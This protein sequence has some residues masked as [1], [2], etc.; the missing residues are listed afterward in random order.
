[1][2][3]PEFNTEGTKKSFTGSTARPSAAI[4]HSRF[5]IQEMRCSRAENL[6]KPQTFFELVAQKNRVLFYSVY[7]VPGLLDDV[8]NKRLCGLCVKSF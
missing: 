8:P 5:K 2:Q 1:M 7:F 4:Q 3:K 6:C